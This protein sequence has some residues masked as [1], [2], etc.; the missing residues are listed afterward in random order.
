MLFVP[1]KQKKGRS[2]SVNEKFRAAL[3]EHL[4]WIDDYLVEA[5]VPINARSLRSAIIFVDACIVEIS[6]ST[7]EDFIHSDK[8]D[9]IVNVIA[10]WY[11]DKYG[12]LMKPK[13]EIL[14]GIVRYY[15]QPVLL[16]IPATT[17]KVETEGETAWLTFPDHLQKEEDY[18]SLFVTDLTFDHMPEEILDALITEVTEV[19]ALTRRIRISIMTASITNDGPLSLMAA[20]IWTHIEKAIFDIISGEPANVSLAC[21]E[22]HLAVEKSLKVYIGQFG[23]EKGWGHDLIALGK[24]A[25]KLGM[26]INETWLGSLHGEKD[27]IKIRYGEIQIAQKEAVESYYNALKLVSVIAGQL[28]R[29]ILINNARIL[30]KMAPW[31]R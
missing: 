31:A 16:R 15:K 10:D 13:Q 22:L 6:N 5:D 21:W 4:S 23:E 14:H 25:K 30:I 3:I 28:K 11:Y 29:E 9:E 12:Q 2:K 26:E 17:T 20:S 27:A 19:V 8:F 1:L 18:K 7:K 24:H